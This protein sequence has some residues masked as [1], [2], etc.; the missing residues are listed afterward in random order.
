MWELNL[1][2]SLGKLRVPSGFFK[3][4]M[5][6]FIELPIQ[7]YHATR[8]LKINML[9]RDPFDLMLIAQSIEDDLVLLTRDRQIL[10]YP[11]QCLE[12]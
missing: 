1:K 7:S 12:A 4:I 2:I 11:I 5:E 8:L 10:Q 3:R 6:D 9:H